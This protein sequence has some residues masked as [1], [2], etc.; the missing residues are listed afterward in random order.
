MQVRRTIA[1]GCVAAALLTSS[2]VPASAAG[3]TGT[4]A[5]RLQQRVDAV[6]AAHPGGRQVSATQVAYD[7]LDVTIQAPGEASTVAANC[8]YGH[9]CMTVRGTNFD[10]YKCQLWT[11]DNWTGDGPFVNNQTPGTVA[12]FF[13]QDGSLRW[14][15][16]A[17]ESGTA[18]WDPIY[19]LKPC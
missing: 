1:A 17:Y 3:R 19:A 7:G 15:S 13:N 8:A 14:T 2:A 18:T 11:V 5:A 10:Y 16:T 4:E 9:L 12:Q 6:L